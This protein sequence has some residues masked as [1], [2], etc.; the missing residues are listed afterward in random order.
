MTFNYRTSNVPDCWPSCRKSGVVKSHSN[1]KVI[2]FSVLTEGA[3]QQAGEVCYSEEKT[4]FSEVI[5]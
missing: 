3:G 1:P 2:V 4:V 5:E